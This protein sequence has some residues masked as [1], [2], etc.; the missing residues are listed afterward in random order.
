MHPDVHVAA[1]LTSW[2]EYAGQASKPDRYRD[3]GKQEIFAGL[4]KVQSVMRDDLVVA[5]RGRLRA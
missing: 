2:G 5:T 4:P 3:S 1:E